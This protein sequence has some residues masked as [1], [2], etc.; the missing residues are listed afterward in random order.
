[1]KLNNLVLKNQP[2]GKVNNQL[3]NPMNLEMMNLILM[4]KDY[5]MTLWRMKEKH[6]D[7]EYQ[8]LM[9]IGT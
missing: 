2:K 4:K 1:M 5:C 8:I 6:L 3:N 7:Q 9:D